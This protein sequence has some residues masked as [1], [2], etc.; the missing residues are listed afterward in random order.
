MTCAEYRAATSARLDGEDTG[1]PVEA[2]EANG[3]GHSCTD[4]ARWLATARR[5]RDL[6]ARAPGPS[7]EWSGG[8]L[9]RLGLG[10]R[11]A[12]SGGGVEGG[13]ATGTAGA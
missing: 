5:L 7:A 11:E 6:S 9:A 8:L 13:S 4:C 12:R 3:H 1:G 2:V 10:G